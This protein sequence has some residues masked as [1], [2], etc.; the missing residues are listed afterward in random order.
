[1]KKKTSFST[2]KTVTSTTDYE[3]VFSGECVYEDPAE[4]ALAIFNEAAAGGPSVE[5]YA[6][7]QIIPGGDF[8]PMDRFV[9]VD[10]IY[11]IPSPIGPQGVFYGTIP[12]SP[13]EQVGVYARLTKA[14]SAQVKVNARLLVD[15]VL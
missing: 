15:G 11:L 8:V 1:M 6:V 12:R 3:L 10:G 7:I 14:G 2:T 9:A 13:L 5:F 4:V